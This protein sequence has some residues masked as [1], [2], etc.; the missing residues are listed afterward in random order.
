LFSKPPK[1]LQYQRPNRRHN[2]EKPLKSHRHNQFAGATIPIADQPS[3]IVTPP[4]PMKADGNIDE[5]ATPHDEA[6]AT[7]YEFM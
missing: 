1:Q 5:T 4:G 7:L 2:T 3:G 6:R